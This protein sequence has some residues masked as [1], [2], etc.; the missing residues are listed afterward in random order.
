MK[1][2][3]FA[4]LSGIISTSCESNNSYSVGTPANTEE[5]KPIAVEKAPILIDIQKIAGRNRKQVETFIGPPD[6]K[7]PQH[8]TDSPCDKLACQQYTYRN[9]QFEIVFINNKADWI[10]IHKVNDFGFSR[11]ATEFL[12][13]PISTPDFAGDG[14]IRWKYISGIN[15]ISIFTDGNGGIDYFYIL[16]NTP[17]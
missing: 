10:T 6:R 14:V 1:N 12:G 11:E 5:A 16:C 15:E 9:G 2:L 17:I 3:L 13:L 4:V 8:V 7:K